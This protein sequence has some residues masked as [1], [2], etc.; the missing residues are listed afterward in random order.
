MSNMALNGTAI[1]LVGLTKRYGRTLAVN[2]LSLEVARGSTFG[3]IG[4]N[5]AGKT[6]TIKM[7][8]GIAP[9][10]CRMAPF[11]SVSTD[12]NGC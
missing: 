5:G 7:L 4:P 9:K 1:E 11:G 3:L 12:V 10:G 8:M 6:T 2:D